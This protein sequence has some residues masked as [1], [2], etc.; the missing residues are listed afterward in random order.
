MRGPSLRRPGLGE[1]CAGIGVERSREKPLGVDRRLKSASLPAYG[2]C[3]AR[4]KVG[5][6]SATIVREIRSDFAV[7]EK[8]FF[9]PQKP[10]PNAGLG[11]PGIGESFAGNPKRF[12][13]GRKEFLFPAKTFDDRRPNRAR[14]SESPFAGMEALLRRRSSPK[15]F[16]RL[17]STPIP[18]QASP[19]PGLRRIGPRKGRTP[20]IKHFYVDDHRPKA[21][22]GCG[23]RRSPRKLRR[24]PVYAGSGEE[25][26]ARRR[27]VG[28]ASQ[29]DIGL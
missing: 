16:E 6:G 26:P 7:K 13:C 4:A 29:I 28:V 10:S 1:A 21:F 8:S 27:K 22:D 23:R 9:F 25:E 2:L 20:G 19:S 17:R 18:A 11:R 5:R 3:A 15:G 24:A 14:A 12:C